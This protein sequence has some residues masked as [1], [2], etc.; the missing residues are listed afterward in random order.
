MDP[1]S[2]GL[3]VVGLGMSIFG[4]LGQA[5]A[6]KEEAQISSEIAGQEQQE[7]N[8]KLQQ[9]AIEN[10]RQNMEII[11][12][13]Q[14]Q[15]ALATAAAVN[16]GAQFG[17]GLQGGLAGVTDQST[18]NLLGSNQSLMFGQQI[19]AINNTISGYKQQLA[20]IQGSSATDAG[21]AS[22]GGA[23]MKSGPTIGAM[24]KG[25]TSGFNFNGFFGGG[26]PSG[27]GA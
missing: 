25:F 27:Y 13:N 15:R 7:N 1:I 10:R 4:G 11:R 23:L 6:Q 21:I 5:K 24:S 12:N 9:M 17:S 14:R 3:G 16:Q 22:L 2:L 18:Y 26:S 19:G 20:S 8:V